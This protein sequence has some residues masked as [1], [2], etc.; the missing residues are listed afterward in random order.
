MT[1]RYARPHRGFATPHPWI[2][3][4][5]DVAQ[6][7]FGAAILGALYVFNVGM[8]VWEVVRPGQGE[9]FR[10]SGGHGARRG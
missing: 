5:R 2:R 3:T 10:P 7:A 8:G 1:R 9:A 4:A 6:F